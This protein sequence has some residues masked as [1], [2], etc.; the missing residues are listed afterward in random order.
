MTV[1][2]LVRISPNVGRC[3]FRDFVLLVG[4]IG[5]WNLLDLLKLLECGDILRSQDNASLSLIRLGTN[6]ARPFHGV[7][8]RL[9]IPR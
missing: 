2:G 5:H 7:I 6:L 3:R 1:L 9:T 8:P 4:A